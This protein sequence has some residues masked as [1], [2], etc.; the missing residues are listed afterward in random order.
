MTDNFEKALTARD[1]LVLAIPEAGF[2]N[3]KAGVVLQNLAKVGW[4]LIPYHHYP[5]PGP[6]GYSPDEFDNQN[7]RMGISD[8]MNAIRAKDVQIANI[9]EALE[10]AYYELTEPIL[11]GEEWKSLIARI[12]NALKV[13]P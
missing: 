1:A 11:R 2:G 5:S 3:V 4:K 9:R 8:Y 6:S 12:E 13:R 10:A 7:K